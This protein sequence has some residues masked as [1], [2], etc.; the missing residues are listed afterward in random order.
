M[1][2][3]SFGSTARERSDSVVPFQNLRA[4][5]GQPYPVAKIHAQFFS[6]LQFAGQLANCT[7]LDVAF[8]IVMR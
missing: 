5:E 8:R 7:L 3:Q 4:T 1:N 2:W 6:D